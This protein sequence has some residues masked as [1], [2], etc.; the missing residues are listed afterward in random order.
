MNLKNNSMQHLILALTL[1]FTSVLIA[2]TQSEENFKNQNSIKVTVVNPLNNNGKVFFGLYTKENF[3]KQPLQSKKGIIENKKSSITFEN[4]PNGV[5]AIICFHDENENNIMD[6]EA[7][8]MPLESYGTSNNPLLMG[9]PQFEVSKF[10]L[11][12]SDL[13]LEIKF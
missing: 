3:R 12:E 6:F 1:M 13:N 2:Q 9:P 8:G 10:E 7:N 5:Y 11:I 4:V